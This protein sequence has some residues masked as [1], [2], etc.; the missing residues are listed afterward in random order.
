M[1]PI[2]TA[3]IA[4]GFSGSVFHTP[5]IKKSDHFNIRLVSSSSAEKVHERLPGI[6][7]TD[8]AEEA[9]RREDIDLVVITSP[10]TTHYPLAKAAMENGKHV[11]LEKPFVP[12]YEEAVELT[13][14]AEANDVVLSVYHN[15]R[16]DGDFLTIRSL[17]NA[18]ALG[19]VHTFQG[20]WNDYAPEVEGLWREQDLPGSG[21]WFDLGAHFVDQALELFGMPETIF[22]DLEM[23]RPK[24][25][26]TDYFHVILG[27]PNQRVILQSSFLA[28]GEVPRYIV[29]GTKGSFVKYGFD[30]QENM[31]IN[32]KMP[33]DK[34]WAV[35]DEAYYGTF[36]DTYGGTEK[37][38]THQGSYETYYEKIAQA[39]Q[40]D[41]KNPVTAIEASRV[42]RLLELAEKSDWEKRVISVSFNK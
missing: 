38:P 2:N 1:Q 10:N 8:E 32:G 42:I 9:C 13:E 37:I 6:E 21:S 34:G 36:T 11:V 7:V 23:Q 29:H 33:G 27:Y 5:I 28:A 17:M 35:E 22:A 16:W 24:T 30:P 19:D 12:T 14:L 3:I 31:L 39:I 40:Q 4:F 26:N 15:R 18:G 25:N 41:G 20:A